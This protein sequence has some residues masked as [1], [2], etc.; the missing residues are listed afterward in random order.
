VIFAVAL[1]GAVTWFAKNDHE[2]T[3]NPPPTTSG[4]GGQTRLP[5]PSEGGSDLSKYEYA[6]R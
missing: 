2:T 5:H 1:V 6:G 4:V 3:N